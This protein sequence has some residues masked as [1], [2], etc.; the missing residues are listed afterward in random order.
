MDFI[1]ANATRILQ[2]KKRLK[3]PKKDLTKQS[4]KQHYL[5]VNL[6]KVDLQ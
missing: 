4:V 2:T 3:G 6:K 5:Q 1:I